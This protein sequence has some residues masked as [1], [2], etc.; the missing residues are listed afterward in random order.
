MSILVF[1]ES[2][3]AAGIC[4]MDLMLIAAEKT[5][6]VEG[7]LRSRGGRGGGRTDLTATFLGSLCPRNPEKKYQWT[8]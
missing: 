5:E 3:V 7:Q 1:R 2:E 6:L 4:D 8:G